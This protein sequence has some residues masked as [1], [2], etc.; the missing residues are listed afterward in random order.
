MEDQPQPQELTPIE[1]K[2]KPPEMLPIGFDDEK[3]Q[4]GS[5]NSRRARTRVGDV[6]LNEIEDGRLIAKL[7]YDSPTFH[8]LMKRV[9]A[10][11]DDNDP[12]RYIEEPLTFD[13][14][15][16]AVFNIQAVLSPHIDEFDSSGHHRPD[17]SRVSLVNLFQDKPDL[18][19][20]LNPP[21]SRED[22]IDTVLNLK[23]AQLAVV[24]ATIPKP[25]RETSG[26]RPRT[27]DLPVIQAM[28]VRILANLRPGEKLP[29]DWVVVEIIRNRWQ[30]WMQLPVFRETYQD[31]IKSLLLNRRHGGGVDNPEPI[32]QTN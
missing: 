30:K 21:F 32:D 15:A 1:P 22:A 8:A 13:R 5:P 28:T 26:P 29:A 16:D 20:R 11:R 31:L 24:T 7:S 12:D 10:Y 18:V 2:A 3:D 25:K 4:L 17:Y 19:G 9:I 23:P 14:A 27:E 6:L